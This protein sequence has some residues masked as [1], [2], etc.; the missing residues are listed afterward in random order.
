[1]TSLLKMSED[2]LA[3]QEDGFVFRRTVLVAGAASLLS[4]GGM[5]LRYA[6]GDAVPLD[7][8]DSPGGQLRIALALGAAM[9]AAAWLIRG[10]VMQ[11]L[12]WAVVVSLLIHFLACL[13]L[14]RVVLDVPIAPFVSMD[15]EE[16]SVPELALPDYGGTESPTSEP[17][18]WERPSN[19]EAEESEQHELDRQLAEITPDAEPEQVD[20][21]RAVQSAAVPN[22]RQQ[23]EQMDAAMQLELQ[24]RRQQ[25]QAEA[26]ER[27]EAPQVETTEVQQPQLDARQMDRVQA[28]PQ[29][30]ARQMERVTAQ[31]DNRVASASLQTPDQMVPRELNDVSVA[32]QERSVVSVD[33]AET[34]AE[35]VELAESASVSRN[36]AERQRVETARQTDV[37]LPSRESSSVQAASG[38]S[39][40][41]RRMSPAR[42]AASASP[43]LPAPFSGGAAAMSRNV[44]S[45]TLSAGAAATAAPSVAVNSV[46][47]AAAPSLNASANAGVA[48]TSSDAPAGATGR[49]GIVSTQTSRSGVTS[50]EAGTLGG[51]RGSQ[52]GPTLGAAVGGSS[53]LAETRGGASGMPGAVGT[54]AEQ[55]AVG[56]LAGSRAGSDGG[57][58]AGPS[59]DATGLARSGTGLPSDTSA[60]MAPGTSTA[61]VSSARRSVA[62]NAIGRSGLSG[63]SSDSSARL[64]G[65]IGGLGQR[66]G[67]PS[68]GSTGISLPDGALRA[69]ESGAL[70]IAGPQAP[71]AGGGSA[72][73]NQ[74]TSGMRIAR[75]G[76]LTGPT[77][78]ASGRRS[79]GLPGVNRGPSTIA[80]SRPSLPGMAGTSPV[81]RTAGRESRP[82]L[83]TASDLAGLIRRNVPGISDFQTERVGAAFSMRT[84][85]ARREAVQELGGNG[86][87]EAAVERGLEWLAAH[88]YA[89]GNWS[90]HEMNCADHDC[91]G[92]GSY[93]ADP[94]ATGLALLAFLGAGNT[95][96]SGTYQQEVRR[97][98][99]WVTLHQKEDGDLFP[100]PSEFAHFYSHGIAAI[101]L[102]EAYGMTKDPDLRDPAQRA[103]QFI[104]QSQHPKFGGWRYEPRFES[105]TS[106]SGWQLMALKSGQMAGLKIPTSVYKGVETWLTSV[107]NNDA[108]GRFRYH[109]STEVT[110]TM[111]AEGLLMRQYLGADKTDSAV[112]A[113]AS[114]LLQRLPRSDAR[115]SYYWYYA[116]QVMF[117]LQG[118][119]WQEWNVALRD[120]LVQSQ[121]KG[122]PV[123]GSWDPAVPVKDTWGQSGGRHYVTCLNLLMLEVYYRHLP[124]YIEL[125]P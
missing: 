5:M 76:S 31:R 101:A 45:V 74:G 37:A 89:A 63:R 97:G 80:R 72:S 69:E 2:E 6:E 64:R 38:G 95:H 113:G 54:Q 43:A 108:P 14:R 92:H 123:R 112:Q 58:G 7:G 51:R 82:R 27:V 21:E 20:V 23:Q 79:A 24:H 119:Y 103:I 48:R 62:L 25:A 33:A 59:S 114:Y 55:V 9:I 41:V 4:L 11:R 49:D 116:T 56:S 17:Q 84:P 40:Q 47:G 46:S 107:E 53:R 71:A 118:E 29:N 19:V 60:G 75:D 98:L 30:S 22:R 68:S 106:V 42:S 88:Q 35:V 8:M 65:T 18:Q 73:R 85:E 124:L 12:Q 50:L 125:T 86:Q 16:I 105:D 77:G 61:G 96:Q 81:G 90:I 13:A 36:V 66:T 115:N 52:A 83:S 94:A 121:E 70:V 102:C 67:R 87:S 39:L 26:I 32:Q 120:M 78:L 57:L 99:N 104:I 117:H 109:P 93:E 10:V 91:T 34:S 44:S 3:K 111:T 15:A 1:M 110:E 28:D 100:A 122:G